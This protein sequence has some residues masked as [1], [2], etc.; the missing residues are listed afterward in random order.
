ME[1]IPGDAERRP[2]RV[3]A[4]AARSA[5][6]REA[7]RDLLRHGLIAVQLDSRVRLTCEMVLRD[8]LLQLGIPES[9]LK[10]TKISTSKFLLRF[11]LLE[12]RNLALSRR[13]LSAGCTT[14]HLMIWSRPAC[15]TASSKLPYRARICIEGVPD[16]AHHVETV[17]HLLPKQS[18]VE[19]IDLSRHKED[20]R[21]CFILWVW[22]KD[23]EALCIAGTLKLEEPLVL[24]EEYYESG[25]DLTHLTFVRAEE[26]SVLEYEVLLHLDHVEDYSPSQSSSSARSFGSDV[27]GLPFMETS[28]E[29]PAR[30][31]F[32]RKLG[33]PDRMP[34]P[35]RVSVHARL[36]AR[37]DR[38]PPRGG[39]TGGL[40]QVPPPNQFDMAR[41]RNGAGSSSRREDHGGSGP[42]RHRAAKHGGVGGMAAEGGR[43][44]KVWR[45]RVRGNDTG[46]CDKEKGMPTSL[47][48][49]DCMEPADTFR[50]GERPPVTRQ[51]VEDP[52][53]LAVSPSAPRVPSG[54][55]EEETKRVEETVAASDAQVMDHEK[56]AGTGVPPPVHEEDDGVVN[57]GLQETVHADL[58]N[59]EQQMQPSQGASLAD[60][61]RDRLVSNLPAEDQSARMEDSLIGLGLHESKAQSAL[62]LS[63]EVDNGLGLQESHA[64]NALGL[65]DEVD[66]I[67]EKAAEEHRELPFDLNVECTAV[68]EERMNGRSQDS[69][70]TE[71]SERVVLRAADSRIN[72]EHTGQ[73]V[74]GRGVNRYAV[75]LRKAL[76][77]TPLMR[78]KVNQSKKQPAATKH[79]SKNATRSVPVASLDEQAA[80][81][82]MRM[83]GILGE[84]EGVTEETTHQFGE[85]LTRPLQDDIVGDMRVTFGLPETGGKDALSGLLGEVGN[86]DVLV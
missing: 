79:S 68:L 69:S 57:E 33:V 50:F 62:G 74:T 24:P 36:G 14:L 27:S 52:K 46:G 47:G 1:F 29:W 15:A 65:S 9:A 42:F 41:F 75:P 12:L 71:L 39:G 38:S 2:D 76:L 60:Q 34:D 19:G 45:P 73:R 80:A 23:P 85:Q 5:V 4:C 49:N 35:P 53:V 63:D 54:Q 13:S 3:V 64:Q 22:C 37:Q 21:G 51:R 20:E 26:L 58:Q 16:H 67:V 83:A 48:G 56:S 55:R 11:N 17:M 44:D 72:K 82:L 30:F 43:R 32:D 31:Y 18:F 70:G 59:A 8:A 25:E 66:N 28:T 6:V 84:G 10:V 61:D 7:E 40:F 86:D 77:C 78:P 81:L